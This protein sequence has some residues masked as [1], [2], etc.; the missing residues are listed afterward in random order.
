MALL[1]MDLRLL[2]SRT[3]RSLS[4]MLGH[5]ARCSVTG[6]PKLTTPSFCAQRKFCFKLNAWLFQVAI[7]PHPVPFEKPFCMIR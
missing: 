6:V 1:T 5:P 4:V 2:P 3:E 7:D